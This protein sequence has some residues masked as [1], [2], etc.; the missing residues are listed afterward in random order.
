MV[1]TS[2]SDSGKRLLRPYGDTTGDGMV[3]LSFTL[4]LSSLGP[5]SKVAEGAAVQL[6]NKMG[7]DPALVVHSKPM[8]PD[9]TFFVVYG[10]VNHLVDPSAVE[11]VERDYELLTPK[12]V[13]AAIKQ[14]LRRRMVVV[15]G[16]IGT[17][18]H[19]VGIDA[20][21]NI[22]GFAG[23]KGL[24]YYRELKVVNL[25][26][27]VS[28][29]QL[30]ERAVEEKADAVLVSQVVTQRDA[31][32]LNTREMSAAFREAFPPARRPLLVVGGPRFDETMAADLGVD[33]VFTR[34]TTPGEVAS[35]LVHRLVTERQASMSPE[36]GITVVHRRYVSYAEA[37]YAG[38]LVD[39][40]WGL[41]LFGDVATEM[42]V[43]T[44][45]DEGLFASYSDVQF[46]AP[47]RAGDVVE[48]RATLT[49]VGRRSREMAFELVV[50][51]RADPR[52]G[53]ESAA[54]TARRAARRDHRHRHRR[55]AGT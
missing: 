3:Q 36:P 12:E 38:N 25:G 20:I 42:C 49:R 9:F 24:E 23:E 26:S 46:R 6:A 41:G 21:L 45:G 7:M 19:T 55:G 29:P 53:S 51:S 5:H 8:G 32:L 30:V 50:V 15:G 13:N 4:P 54:A 43:R 18:A 35:Y 47:V 39:G 2:S 31:H 44:D 11:V 28:V 34:G 48:A 37:H 14:S 17:D 40:A 27:Q 33:R 52:G 22:K 10:R 16:C 1:A